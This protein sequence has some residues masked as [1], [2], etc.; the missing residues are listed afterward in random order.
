MAA[1]IAALSKKVLGGGAL[2]LV[3]LAIGLG[4][5][6]GSAAALYFSSQSDALTAYRSAPACA[7]FADAVAG[8]SCRYTVTARVKQVFGDSGSADV[9]FD[10]PGQYSQFW[11]ATLGAGDT[12][13]SEGDQ[14]QIEVWQGKVTRIG[15]TNTYDNPASDPRLKTLFAIGLLL[16]PFG[17][18]ATAWGI[19]RLRRSNGQA[20]PPPTMS[21]VAMSDV[22]WR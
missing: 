2:T 6:A 1:A 12:W 19:V 9:Y 13:P 8:E 15:S 18:G 22:L 20:T 14:V 5:L 4:L 7:T 21:P 11:M 10:V 16:L 3:W 17:L